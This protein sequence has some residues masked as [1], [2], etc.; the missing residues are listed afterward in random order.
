MNI[1]AGWRRTAGAAAVVLG[2]A[3]TEAR[4]ETK[5]LGPLRIRD[6]T[7][8]YLPLSAYDFTGGFLDGT[9]EGFHRTFGLDPNGRDLVARNR[10]QG[11]LSVEGVKTSFLSPPVDG[12]MGDPVLGMRHAWP[13]RGSRWG[14]VLGGAAKIAWRGERSFLSTGTNDYGLQ[15][16][17]QGKYSRQAVYF[18]ASAVR[19]DGRAFGVPLKHRLTPTLTAAYE[20]GVAGHTNLVLQLYASQSTILDTTIDQLK[21]D[22][23]QA[24]FGLRSF[25]GHMIYGF[26]V[27]ENVANFANTP[28]V[29]VALTLALVALRPWA[30]RAGFPPP[31]RQIDRSRLRAACPVRLPARDAMELVLPHL[32]LGEQV[33]YLP[34]VLDGGVLEVEGEPVLRAA[35][36]G[37]GRQVGEE[38]QVQGQRRGQDRVAT[39][40]I[41]LDLHRIAQP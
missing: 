5:L 40:E 9:I 20:V 39:E 25:R 35:Q 18:T 4:G 2:L 33:V 7:P 26:A 10:F 27:T 30:R 22:K 17:L 34:S 8:V 31:P 36:A 28:D 23:F 12:G 3:A 24:N 14:L 13:L 19:T 16:S 1:R 38:G 29:G 11:V 32:P 6:M 37:A 15:A 41:D 21:A